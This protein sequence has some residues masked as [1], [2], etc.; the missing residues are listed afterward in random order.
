MPP[1]KRSYQT[2]S[3]NPAKGS[4]LSPETKSRQG[5]RQEDSSQHPPREQLITVNIT[6]LS[7]VKQ[8]VVEALVERTKPSPGHSPQ[9]P[10]SRTVSSRG[11]WCI[12]GFYHTG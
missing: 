9:A 5:S 8:A 3:A 11:S 12:I 2:R 4:G 1:E 10:H 7:A 6:A